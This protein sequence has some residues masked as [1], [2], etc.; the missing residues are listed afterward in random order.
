[1]RVAA[2]V[3]SHGRPPRGVRTS[4]GDLGEGGM[5]ACS[6]RPSPLISVLCG[7]WSEHG[8]KTG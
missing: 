3:S 6:A 7:R 2:S 8:T 5:S 4:C 1:M